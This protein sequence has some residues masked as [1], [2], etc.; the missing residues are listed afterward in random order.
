MTMILI[1][2]IIR[3]G[4]TGG[5]PCC[6]G[7]SAQLIGSAYQCIAD[8]STPTPQSVQCMAAGG[9]PCGLPDIQP[10]TGPG[11]RSVFLYM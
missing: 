9:D 6:E 4:P 3:T 5:I 1:M 11:K 8:E 7:S 2:M 10:C